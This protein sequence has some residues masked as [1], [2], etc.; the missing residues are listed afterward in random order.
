[1]TP[2][3]VR[4]ADVDGAVVTR[5]GKNHVHR[6]RYHPEATLPYM[7]SQA[8][9][10]HASAVTARQSSKLVYFPIALLSRL[11]PTYVLTLPLSAH[12]RPSEYHAFGKTSLL[13]V[14]DPPSSSAAIST[15]PRL[16]LCAI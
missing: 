13:E 7:W 12:R 8:M 5:D 11:Y 9:D 6:P 3:V 16:V 4:A 10:L 14:S 2:L 1:M 15:A